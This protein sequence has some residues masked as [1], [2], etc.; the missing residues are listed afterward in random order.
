[1]FYNRKE[2]QKTIINEKIEQEHSDSL[3]L[4]EW[5]SQG[6][7]RTLS[8]ATAQAQHDAKLSWDELCDPQK[9]SWTRLLQKADQ[10]HKKN[11][12]TYTKDGSLVL[13]GD[14]AWETSSKP[15]RISSEAMHMAWRPK[16]YGN[17]VIPKEYVKK[18]LKKDKVNIVWAMQ[19]KAAHCF[20][21]A[22]TKVNEIKGKVT[23]EEDGSVNID[24]KWS[25]GLT[26]VYSTS[27]SV[28]VLHF[29]TF[30]DKY[31]LV[32]C[33]FQ[34]FVLCLMKDNKGKIINTASQFAKL[35]KE[36]DDE[37]NAE[38]AKRYPKF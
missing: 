27:S 25:R 34:D 37:R 23:V 3:T 30:D 12:S 38:I 7:K 36:I 28:G 29:F 19:F 13:G 22:F 8:T 4:N 18:A 5:M 24:G 26:K 16:E 6:T 33:G 10:Y 14:P 15:D 20:R 31:V 32:Q 17:V 9:S 1:M 35:C 21:K 11:G 2:I